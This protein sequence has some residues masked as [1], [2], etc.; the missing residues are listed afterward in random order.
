MAPPST[1]AMPMDDGSPLPDCEDDE[2]AA[3]W[4]SGV[5]VWQPTHWLPGTCAGTSTVSTL[6][7]PTRKPFSAV[8]FDGVQYTMAPDADAGAMRNV[9]C[10]ALVTAPVACTTP[11]TSAVLGRSTECCVSPFQTARGMVH[12]VLAVKTTSGFLWFG[13]RT[14]SSNA[15]SPP[16]GVNEK[17]GRSQSFGNSVPSSG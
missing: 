1:E 15:S 10:A 9:P 5:D 7:S 6:S 17:R 13:A 12:V 3:N 2:K 8:P 4:P 14:V 11:S 16:A